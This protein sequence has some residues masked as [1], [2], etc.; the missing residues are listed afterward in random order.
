MPKTL[1][2]NG[3][4]MESVTANGVTINRVYMNGVLVFEKTTSVVPTLSITPNGHSLPASTLSNRSVTVGSNTDWIVGPTPDWFSVSGG[5]GN[6]NG[7]FSITDIQDNTT[8]S[9][10]NYALNISTQGANSVSKTLNINQNEADTLS[11]DP[12]TA[13]PSSNQQ[14]YKVDI[15]TNRTFTVTENASWIY[16]SDVTQTQSGVAHIN[17]NLRHNPDASTRTGTVTFTAGELIVTHQVNQFGQQG[18]G[19]NTG[20]G[21]STPPPNDN[22]GLIRDNGDNGDNELEP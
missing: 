21:G 14:T 9:E 3:T 20:G 15:F 4:Q 16:L 7:E 10:K 2:V 11:I 22:G 18:G 12:E 6:G 13:E 5:S 1:N 8:S 19:G 17:I